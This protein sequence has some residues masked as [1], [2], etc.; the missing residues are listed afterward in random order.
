[1]LPANV[2]LLSTC[3]SRVACRQAGDEVRVSEVHTAGAFEH[4]Q[5]GML[6]HVP[7]DQ[8]SA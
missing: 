8:T 6:T 7:V 4:Q 2:D 3:K 1:M 5:T